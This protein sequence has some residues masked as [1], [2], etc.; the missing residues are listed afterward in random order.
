M[1]PNS[2]CYSKETLIACIDGT[3]P[4]DEREAVETH[5]AG[6]DACAKM[7]EAVKEQL[8]SDGVADTAS[9]DLPD[10]VWE[11]GSTPTRKSDRDAT[12]LENLELSQ[13]LEYLGK[14]KTYDIIRVLGRG[15]YGTVFEAKD[16]A[17]HRTVAIKVL[18]RDLA[19]SDVS[20][21]RFIREARAGAAI[22]HPNVVTIHAVEESGDT[23]FLVMEL[24]QGETLRERIRHEPKLDLL[25][26]LRISAQ[27]AQGLAAAH[28]QGII[29]RDVKPG[30]IMLVN[31]TSRVKIADFGLARVAAENVEL[32][33]HGV[34]I[35]TPAYMSPEQVRGEELD[36]RSDL[37]ALG[38]VM[39][40]MVAGHS[41]FHG[42]STLDIA[43]RIQSHDPP[44]LAEISKGI[45]EFLDDIVARLLE[46][47][48]EHRFQSAAEVADVLSQ[49]L[50]ILNQT[51]TDRFPVALRMSMLKPTG[52]KKRSRWPIVLAASTILAIAAI[53][54]G[55]FYFGSGATNVERNGGAN[56]DPAAEPES[57]P[58]VPVQQR[59]PEVTVSKT[60][61]ADFTTIGEA[62]RNVAAGGT[63]TIQD[64]AEYNETIRL[65]DAAQYTGVRIVAPNHAT[66]Q[67]N[68]VGPVVTIRSIPGLR[69]EGLTV[70]APQ[71]QLGI[72]ISGECP[73]LEIIDTEIRRIANPEGADASVAGVV[74][75]RG[76]AGAVDEPIR[77]RG[78]RLRDTDVG[79]V[80]GNSSAGADPPKHIVIE[81]CEVHGL[82]EFSST[83]LVLLYNVEDVSIHRNIFSNG[84]RGI[85][86]VVEGPSM[87]LRCDLSYNTWHLLDDWFGWTGDVTPPLSLEIHHNLIVESRLYR[88][89]QDFLDA[90]NTLP[91]VFTGNLVVDPSGTLGEQFS[92][93][94][95]VVEKIPFLSLTPSNPDYLKP[96]FERL[97]ENESGLM[98]ESVPGRYSD[99]AVADEQL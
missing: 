99:P 85:S 84:M 93:L 46:K 20:R 40:S 80:I 39:Y 9:E 5:V 92:N 90:I 88:P 67:S 17:L 30:N 95:E 78:L 22:N 24:I 68:A 35:G 28:A 79:I 29:H 12:Q 75:H 4:A 14:L 60:D 59:K 97:K 89:L 55:W 49:H 6:C 33:S 65:T 2:D 83:L 72:E 98:P 50:A 7:A 74:L 87:P 73:G 96:D 58:S 41:P 8:N 86:I 61:A 48:L 42:K 77:L 27:I 64:D 94:A 57:P 53:T 13:T 3:L 36:S 34:A 63:V 11:G 91:P 70:L 23:P 54:G 1:S 62:L 25:D 37:F 19:K 51:P 47:D 16:S 81:Q 31:P 10:E 66:V 38:C 44:R 15:G 71:A 18:N 45:P 82:S 69:L 32:T 43:M 76:A 56:T 52:D 21:R 26:I